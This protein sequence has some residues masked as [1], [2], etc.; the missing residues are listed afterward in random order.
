MDEMVIPFLLVNLNNYCKSTTICLSDIGEIVRFVSFEGRGERDIGTDTCGVSGCVGPISG[1][2]KMIRRVKAWPAE[3]LFEDR[4]GIS[5]WTSPIR[6]E[7][8]TVPA[9]TRSPLF[10]PSIRIEESV[11]IVAVDK[12]EKCFLHKVEHRGSL[13]CKPSRISMR[14]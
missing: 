12:L 6:I 11:T 14:R 13:T 3:L 8:A 7:L 4:N 10:K 2:Y 9:Y 1:V 5:N